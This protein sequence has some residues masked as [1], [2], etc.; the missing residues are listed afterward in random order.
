VGE[1]NAIELEK[2]LAGK[3]VRVSPYITGLTE[4]FSGS[5]SPQD[6]ETMFQ[7]IYLYFTSPRKD[8]TAFQSYKTRMKGFIKNRSARPETAFSD[9]IQVTMAQHHFRVRPWTEKLLDEMNLDK[10]YQIYR[11]RFAD[12]SDFVFFFVGNFDKKQMKPLVSKYLGSLPA[13]HRNETWKDVGIR[14]PQG[15]IEKVVKKG[16]EPKSQVRIIFSGP[17]EWNRE[18]NYVLR[19]MTSAMQ[20]KLREILRE[21]KSGTYGVGI[22][23]SLSHYPKEEYQINIAFGCD[24]T[25]VEELTRTLFQQIDSLKNYGI[26][27]SYIAKVKEMQIRQYETDLKRNR[28]WLNSL[29]T[30]YM[31]HLD[32]ENILAF[33]QLVE[34]LTAED[35]HQAAKKYFNMNNYVRVVLYPEKEN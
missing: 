3:V 27:E 7:L 19:S 26:K 28:F 9:T 5:A 30:A 31:H 14:P 21:E 13:L 1:F 34:T 4:G 16:I 20:I 23:P 15:V 25:R 29:N 12:A 6:L 33:K 22:W 2:K 35:V 24:P 11:D 18:N 8:E 32:P 10:S 17:Y